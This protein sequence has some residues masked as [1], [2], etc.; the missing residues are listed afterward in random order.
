[1]P[2]AGAAADA[3]AAPETAPARPLPGADAL[4]ARLEGLTGAPAAGGQEELARE[5]AAAA[6]RLRERTPPREEGPAPA[7][8]AA[9]IA[10]S[11]PAVAGEPTTQEIVQRPVASAGGMPPH[12][13]APARRPLAPRGLPARSTARPWLRDAV[14]AL[15]AEDVA[16]AAQLVLA[17][18]PVQ[19][20][21]AARA[22][23]Y[24]L[25][26][27]GARAV[28]VEVAPGL[29]AALRP[30]EA[31]DDRPDLV[32]V[33]TP[34]ALAPL[35]G[36]GAGRRLPGLDVGGRRR[37]LRARL[38][39]DMRTPVS[40]ADVARARAVPEPEMLLRALCLAARPSWVTAAATVEV[41]AGSRRRLVLA[42]G[43]RPVLRAPEGPV[44]AGLHTTAQG[45]PAVLAGARPAGG[46]PAEAS[47]DA[48][49]LERFFELVDRVQSGA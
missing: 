43:R 35:V 42:P 33:G 46:P 24:D 8:P 1:R 47:G 4:R 48:D 19:G 12:C 22:L 3:P 18:V 16:A 39:R 17:L 38:A 36:G 30:L 23:R 45:L 13:A 6:S 14:V 31:T 27:D 40:L 28:R 7:V 49:V 5:L 32:L 26:V 34:E 21:R 9:R 2:R 20:L 15:A 29:P 11:P 25:H 44:D 41:E 10:P 37:W